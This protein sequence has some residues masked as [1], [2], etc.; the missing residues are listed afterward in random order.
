MLSLPYHHAFPSNRI[1]CMGHLSQTQHLSPTENLVNVLEKGDILSFL[2]HFSY[3]PIS[4]TIMY[5]IGDGL[6][7][8]DWNEFYVTGYVLF[9]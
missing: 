1:L 4:F 5:V 9:V 3:M 8:Q 6:H 7:K 2:V